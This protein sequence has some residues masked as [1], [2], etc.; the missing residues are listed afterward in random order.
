MTNYKNA[1]KHI[2]K[3]LNPAKNY[4]DTNINHIAL[5]ISKW[6][7]YGMQAIVKEKINNKEFLNLT[8]LLNIICTHYGIKNS[9]VIQRKEN[10]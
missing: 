6:G 10:K 5:K 7:K 2:Q 4:S 8:K 9:K 1:K 3:I